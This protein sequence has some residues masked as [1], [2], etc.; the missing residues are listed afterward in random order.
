MRRREML[1]GL[2]GSLLSACATTPASAPA[3]TP[4][5]TPVPPVL[6]RRDRILKSVVGLRPH[7]DGGFRLEREPFLGKTLIHN[8]GHSGDGVSL[9]PGSS[10]VAAEMAHQTGQRETAVL[11][12]GVMGLTTA[13]LLAAWGHRVTVYAADFPP[14]TTSNIAGALILTPDSQNRTN[15]TTESRA[16]DT[17]VSEIS[18]DIWYGMAGQRRYGVKL[19]NHYFLG[20]AGSDL[21][22]GFLGRRVRRNFNAVMVDPGIYL[23][24]L[25]DDVRSAGVALEQRRFGSTLELERLAQPVI[26]NCTG[27]GAGELFLDRDMHALRGQLTLLKPQPEIDYSYIARGARRSS[28]YMFPREGSIVLGGTRERDVRVMDIDEATVERMM[29]EHGAMAKLAGGR[30]VGV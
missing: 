30:R 27:L 24:A 19:V 16:Q 17:R 2:G 21:E 9:S 5:L 18:D 20:S 12:A 8:Y 4:T 25:M 3:S 14:N 1:A 11:G 23:K 28:L 26:V 6:V 15:P 7:R 22:S 13:R 29:R 10:Q